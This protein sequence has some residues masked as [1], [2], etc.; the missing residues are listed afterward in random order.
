MLDPGQE[1]ANSCATYSRQLLPM[2]S[3]LAW[4]TV[5][6]IADHFNI[7]ELILYVN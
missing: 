2:L 1:D 5:A 3:L 7:T 4:L 6:T